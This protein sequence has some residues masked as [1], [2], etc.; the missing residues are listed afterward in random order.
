MEIKKL[1]SSSQKTLFSPGH[2]NIKIHARCKSV[3][4]KELTALQ[5]L[6]AYKP[7]VLWSVMV[8][9]CA[10]MEGY[11]TILIPNFYAFPAFAAKYGTYD[12]KTDTNQLTAAWQVALGNAAGI[13]AFFGIM[14]NGILVSW[15]GHKKVLL[16]SLLVL[17]FLNTITFVAQN[18]LVLFLGELLCGLPWGI[19]ATIAPA[20]SSEVLPLPLRTY[21]T[22]YT[23]I[24]FIIGQ[25]FAAGSL[26]GFL[27]VKGSWSY[28]GAFALQWVWILFIFPVL[29]FMPESPWR[30]VRLGKIGEAE[31]ILAR[32]QSKGH[33]DKIKETLAMI[34]RTNSDEGQ[35]LKGIDYRDCFRGTERRRTE[36]A[37]MAAA[38]QM[39][40]GLI[41]AYSATYFYQ[42]IHLS[43]SNIYRLN[44]GGSLLSLFSAL[45]SWFFITPYVGRRKIY[46]SGMSALS[47]I[48]FLIGF[49]GIDGSDKVVPI[50]QATL[51]FLWISIF[52]ISA[53]Q[54]GWAIPAEVGSTRLRQ[55]T[56]CLARGFFHII[57]LLGKIVEPY[58]MNPTQLN[59]KGF[60]AFF[61]G[62]T[63]L[64]TAIW[65]YFRLPE[66]KDRSFEELNNL[67][68]R[69]VPTRKFT[70]RNIESSQDSG[71][72]PV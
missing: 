42:Q 24:C 19:I 15:F 11:D 21:L 54:L 37:C 10:V 6:R 17:T 7:A 46:F 45:V 18:T 61:W 58:F 28:R 44:L 63:S 64:L 68:A 48:L 55:K 53:G 16:A 36:I 22:S 25:I 27:S 51:I 3:N 20:Y 29:L 65:I 9:M 60:T 13:G 57:N 72:K 39:L 5:A 62:G 40:A 71:E 30:L 66:T 70:S 23:N 47:V 8:C 41:F 59:L 12:E 14:A 31:D 4:V 50:L 56:I 38:G 34:I 49:L 35:L 67:F 52:Q 69:N 1:E 32:L 43:T 33:R 2:G 26:D